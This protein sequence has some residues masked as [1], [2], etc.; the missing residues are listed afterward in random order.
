[1]SFDLP[2]S[3]IEQLKG[4]V[5]LCRTKPEIIHKPELKF[6]LDFLVSMGAS[7]P[8]P[9]PASEAKPEEEKKAKPEEPKE[10]APKEETPEDAEM[11]SDE[12]DLELDMEGVLEDPDSDEEH[13]MGDVNKKEM[14]DEE[15]E[16]F[17]EVRSN[18]MGTY[19]EGEWGK[20]IEMFT[21]AIKLNPNSAAMFAKRGAC[22]LKL[23]KPKACIRDCTRAIELNPDN[24]SAYKFRGRSNRLLGNF[25]LAA[26]DLRTFPS[27]PRTSELPAKSISMNR[28]T[29]G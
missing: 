6:F 1:M 10:D 18:A 16:K 23:K 4:F 13:E 20:A 15:M 27:R 8:P 22:F 3:A 21:D 19:S 29:N 5:L 12:S 17:D 25:S 11:S 9:P 14:T 28:L 24:A 26:K 2:T 7:I